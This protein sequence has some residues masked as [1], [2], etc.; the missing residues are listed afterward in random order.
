M[1]PGCSPQ[2]KGNTQVSFYI[3]I[4]LCPACVNGHAEMSLRLRRVDVT[5]RRFT[6]AGHVGM[7]SIKASP[8]DFY[9]GLGLI[10]VHWQHALGT[11]GIESET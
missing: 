7:S 10:K 8:N 3:C 1:V 2:G 11:L 9:L 4:A 5:V 6:G